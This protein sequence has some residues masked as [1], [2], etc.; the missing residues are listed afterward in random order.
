MN[1][2][3]VRSSSR[4]SESILLFSNTTS[5]SPSFSASTVTSFVRYAQWCQESMTVKHV[6]RY[7]ACLWVI[8]L[9]KACVLCIMDHEATNQSALMC[10]LHCVCHAY[11]LDTAIRQTCWMHSSC[12]ADCFL[13][14]M[15]KHHPISGK[16]V[17]YG[18]ESAWFTGYVLL[19]L[20]MVIHRVKYILTPT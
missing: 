19:S 4:W 7:I 11:E 10:T 3:K 14:Y 8:L 20:N 13:Y 18:T 16:H 9:S 17:T 6:S 12:G 15:W 1:Q 5:S 2:G